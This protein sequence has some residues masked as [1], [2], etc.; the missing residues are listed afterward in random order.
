MPEI[1][2]AGASFNV[3]EPGVLSLVSLNGSVLR[4]VRQANS[5]QA[6]V[7]T[8]NLPKGL[9]LLRFQ[10]ETSAPQTRKLLVQ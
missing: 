5:R 10:G 8:A 9:Y 7:P 4:S 2:S 6:I 1:T 3:G